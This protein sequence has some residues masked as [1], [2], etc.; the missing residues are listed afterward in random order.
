ML[1][2]IYITT[3][4]ILLLITSKVSKFNGALKFLV[5]G[6]ISYIFLGLIVRPVILYFSQP[7][8]EFGDA[9]ADSR[10]IVNSSYD[11]ALI[12]IGLY[13]LFGI[14]IFGISLIFVEK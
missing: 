7:N 6:Q 12:K 14:S 1:I 4:I 5:F 3:F 8:P 9:F 11:Q 2:L 10:L 13:I